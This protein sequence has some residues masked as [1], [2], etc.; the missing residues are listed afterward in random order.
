MADL[1]LDFEGTSI[2]FSIVVVLAYFPAAV[3]E[4][5]FSPELPTF[6]GGGVLDGSYSN[7]NEVES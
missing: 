1:C 4:S 7:R 3:Y 6:V 2:L 5:L